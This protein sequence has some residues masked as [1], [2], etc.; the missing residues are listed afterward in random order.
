[1]HIIS[2]RSKLADAG[3]QKKLLCDINAPEIDKTENYRLC[4]NSIKS[5]PLKDTVK[6]IIFL[7]TLEHILKIRSTEIIWNSRPEYR[8][9]E[10][11]ARVDKD[12]SVYCLL[13]N[14]H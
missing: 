1:M 6:G 5:I 8:T 9:K 4:L 14:Y 2:P 3:K 11:S 10:Q 7:E 12:A 13:M